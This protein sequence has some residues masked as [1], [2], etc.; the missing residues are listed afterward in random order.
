MSEGAETTGE[1]MGRLLAEIKQKDEEIK[2]KD[3]KI[4]LLEKL[5]MTDELTG[6]ANRRGFENALQEESERVARFGSS[7]TL[8]IIDLD[9]FKLVNDGYGH[10]YGDGVLTRFA[11]LL[12]NTLR[13]IDIKTRTGGDEFA[14]ILPNTPGEHA[15][16]A[17]KRLQEKFSVAFVKEISEKNF[18]MS[19]GVDIFEQGMDK[20]EFINRVDQKLYAEKRKNKVQKQ[21]PE[22]P[23]Y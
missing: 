22:V 16:E 9:N 2:Q 12:D 11:G 10:P 4:A 13:Q 14:A 3:E 23:N 6:L 8:L 21:R 19:V 17:I 15:Q 18:G 7:F 20:E 1:A 5:A